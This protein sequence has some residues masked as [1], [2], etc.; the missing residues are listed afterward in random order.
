MNTSENRNGAP[1]WNDA[2][3]WCFACSYIEKHVPVVGGIPVKG[4]VRIYKSDLPPSRHSGKLFISTSWL[5]Q[6]EDL[7][8]EIMAAWI[9]PIL[10]T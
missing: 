3:F 1:S 8:G 10:D 2:A 6:Q 7:W 9:G 4:E 5:V